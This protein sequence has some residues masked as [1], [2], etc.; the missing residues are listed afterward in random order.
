MEAQLRESERAP[1]TTPWEDARQRGVD[2]RA[3][4]QEPGWFLEIYEGNRTLIALDY[5]ERRMTV[6]TPEPERDRDGSRTFYRVAIP[7]DRV[8]IEIRDEPCEDIMS[9]ERFEA[10]VVVTV[11]GEEF[12]GCGRAL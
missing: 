3:I 9:G 4:G 12:Q 2:F 8:V 1:G 7:P 5:G 6:R 10:T 11:D